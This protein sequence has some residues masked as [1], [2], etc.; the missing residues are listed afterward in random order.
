MAAWEALVPF[1]D[2]ARDAVA[3]DSSCD[4]VVLLQGSERRVG[5]VVVINW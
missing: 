1:F 5:D 2:H 4:V 3:Q